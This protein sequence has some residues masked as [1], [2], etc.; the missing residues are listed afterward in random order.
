MIEVE[1]ILD[2]IEYGYHATDQLRIH[3]AL[4]H[5]LERNAGI[6]QRHSFRSIDGTKN[7]TFFNRAQAMSRAIPG[8]LVEILQSIESDHPSASFTMEGYCV[9]SSGG[10]AYYVKLGKPGDEEQYNGEAASIEHITRAAPGLCPAVLRFGIAKFPGIEGDEDAEMID[11]PFWVSEYKFVHPL[12]PNSA[13]VLAKRLALE[14]H[15]YQ[16][17]NGTLSELRISY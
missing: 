3:V 15:A 11:K 14:L 8:P 4:W 6:L 16:S 7:A 2:F 10:P 12:D 5:T 9:R 1:S 13:S 17:Q